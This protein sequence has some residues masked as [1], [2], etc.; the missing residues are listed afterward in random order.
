LDFLSVRLNFH[1]FSSLHY[2]KLAFFER[3]GIVVSVASDQNDVRIGQRA[4]GG[5]AL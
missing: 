2:K 3:K 5:L 4:S 1:N